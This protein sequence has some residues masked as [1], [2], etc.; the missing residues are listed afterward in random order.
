MD[1]LVV[2]AV[3]GFLWILMLVQSLAGLRALRARRDSDG[4]LV[5]G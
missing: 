4:T 1:D 3:A 5:A 2:H